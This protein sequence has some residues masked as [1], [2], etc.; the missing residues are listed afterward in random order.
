[1]LLSLLRYR[2]GRLGKRLG[3]IVSRSNGRRGLCF[4]NYRFRLRRGYCRRLGNMRWDHAVRRSRSR[5]PS[6]NRNRNH[7]RFAKCLF[8]V[9]CTK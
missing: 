4:N 1:M 2:R 5:R 7:S 3:V 6:L 8:S 9:L